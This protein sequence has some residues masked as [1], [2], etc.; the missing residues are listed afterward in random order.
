MGSLLCRKPQILVVT[1]GNDFHK[2]ATASC[3]H[4]DFGCSAS[5]VR[6]FLINLQSLP[7]DRGGNENGQNQFTEVLE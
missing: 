4:A 3:P 5:S 1:V 6:A 7:F 2:A